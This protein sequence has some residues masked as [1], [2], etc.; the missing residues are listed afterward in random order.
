MKRLAAEPDV[1]RD[2]LILIP[3]CANKLSGGS[4]GP[5]EPDV[6]RES[7]PSSSYAR[8]LSSRLELAGCLK[9]I[10]R[11]TTKKYT[12]NNEL[13]MGEDFGLTDTEGQYLPAI[14][15]YV[16]NLYKAHRDVGSAIRE[17]TCID[18]EPK[19]PNT[20]GFIRTIASA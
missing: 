2:T 15:R 17:C 3:C 13:R 9:S 19:L 10:T 18:E 6:L 16:G 7:V 4:V 11:Y 20:F 8:V 12:K 5:T 1:G 14:D